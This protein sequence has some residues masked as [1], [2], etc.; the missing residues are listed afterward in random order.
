MDSQQDS[1][2]DT[3]MLKTVDYLIRGMKYS[4]PYDSYMLGYNNA[5]ED[6]L[7]AMKDLERYR[8]AP[9]KI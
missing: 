6:V 4:A 8:V 3:T 5:L 9:D 2:N 1:G 7:Q